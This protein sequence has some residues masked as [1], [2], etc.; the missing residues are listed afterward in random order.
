[1]NTKKSK[2]FLRNLVLQSY[3]LMQGALVVWAIFIN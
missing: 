1:M 2:S 3:S